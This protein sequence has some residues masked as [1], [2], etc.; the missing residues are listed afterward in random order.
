MVAMA[1]RH[2]EAELYGI[3]GRIYHAALDPGRWDG[4]LERLIGLLGADR[5]VFFVADC[6]TGE[7]GFTHHFNLPADLDRAYGEYFVGRD[8]W[9]DLAY[10]IR[11]P[12][13]DV[14]LSH[15][16][17]PDADLIRTEFYNDF[18]RP[19]DSHYGCGGPF[20][21]DGSVMSVMN[22][23][24]SKRGGP[25]EARELALMGRLMPHLNRAV[26]IHR[27]LCNVAQERAAAEAALDRLALG[28]LFVDGGGRVL[29]MNKAA[30][31][32][33]AAED[34]FSLDRAGFCRAAR[35]EDSRALRAAMMGAAAGGAGRGLGAGG[36]FALPRPSGLRPYAVLVAPIAPEYAL[37]GAEVPVAAVFISDPE[38]RH[39]TPAEILCRLYGLTDKQ[40]RLAAGIVAGRPLRD[41]AALLRITEGTA[42]GYLKDVFR[43][44][45]SRRQSDLV[46]FV[47]SGPAALR[48]DVED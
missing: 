7:A 17:Y 3:V 40:A 47:L 15:E 23:H 32:V 48:G 36:A 1:N 26:Q 19:M 25:F 14:R 39:E 38:R 31:E 10:R 22:A 8:V 46:A 20:R 2:D 29:H 12:A 5:L 9:L 33:A 43:K 21:Y 30:R 44:T 37:L 13:G 24:R 18:L 6:E 28:V 42:R 11:I 16:F 27:R 45:G 41:A 35:L 4:A 34:G